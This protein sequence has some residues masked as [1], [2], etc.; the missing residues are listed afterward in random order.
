MFENVTKNTMKELIA[1]GPVS[2]SIYVD[3]GLDAY[4]SGVYSGCPA[5]FETSYA[6]LNHVLVVVGY[7][8]EGNYIVKN[9]WGKEWGINGFGVISKDNDCGITA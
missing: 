8:R 3:S 9:S 6:N 4:K 7:D 1:R 5:S 2:A